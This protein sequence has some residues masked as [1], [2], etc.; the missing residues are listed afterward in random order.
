VFDVYPT[1][2]LWLLLAVTPIFLLIGLSMGLLISSLA[3]SSADAVERTVLMMVPQMMLSD[4]LFPLSLMAL[5]FRII[6]EI[7]P[8][9][10]YL[11]VTRG[12]YLKGLGFQE[13]WPEVTFL[14]AFLL[15]IVLGVSRTIKK[16]N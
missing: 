1:G 12:V 8:L 6:G 13:L 4:F 11:R 10:H 14:C 7:L 9:T 2:K 16:H 15:L 5:P 3:Q